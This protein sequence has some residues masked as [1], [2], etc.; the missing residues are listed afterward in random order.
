M[1]YLIFYILGAILTLVFWLWHFSKKT[2][3]L[4]RNALE[5]IAF[6]SILFPIVWVWVLKEVLVNIT[7]FIYCEMRNW[8][9]THNDR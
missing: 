1:I 9:N 4:G 8:R 3:R 2:R 6:L 5:K 7:N